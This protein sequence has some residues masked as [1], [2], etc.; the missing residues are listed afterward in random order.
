MNASNAF[1]LMR[2]D[3]YLKWF[4]PLLTGSSG[5]QDYSAAVLAAG[6]TAAAIA[7]GTG[8]YLAGGGRRPNA[9]LSSDEEHDNVA[10]GSAD[11]V[12][13]MAASV[14]ARNLK[15]IPVTLADKVGCAAAP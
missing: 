7:G 15:A 4:A 2:H 8:E 11:D 10:I 1:Q 5:L 12:A 14:R 3:G 13:T 9:A 6:S